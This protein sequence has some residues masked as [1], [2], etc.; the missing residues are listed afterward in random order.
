MADLLIRKA[1]Y[2]DIDSIVKIYRAQINEIRAFKRSFIDMYRKHRFKIYVL[3]Q[4][5]DIIGFYTVEVINGLMPRKFVKGVKT[6]WVHFIAVSDHGKGYGRI[7]MDNIEVMAYHDHYITGIGLHSNLRSYPF[8]EKMGLVIKGKVKHGHLNKLYMYKD[9]DSAS[10]YRL[11]IEDM[12]AKNFT[13]E[14]VAEGIVRLNKL[15]EMSK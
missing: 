5:K 4:D 14:D 3:I 11:R 9:L 6:I 7:L 12:Q 8:Y 1:N 15:K 13:A 2:F 10:K